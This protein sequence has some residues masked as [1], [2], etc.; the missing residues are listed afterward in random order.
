MIRQIA[1]AVHRRQTA[2]RTGL[3]EMK[4]AAS[5]DHVERR[6]HHW[7]GDDLA[8][9]ALHK[10]TEPTLELILDLTEGSLVPGWVEDE[11][12]CAGFGSHDAVQLFRLIAR[13]YF[14]RGDHVVAYRRWSIGSD[15]AAAMV[16]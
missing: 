15:Y 3:I 14:N 11:I 7:D 2:E 10:C 6:T 9:F 5:R 12:A 1:K 13:R 4:V 16:H 8:V